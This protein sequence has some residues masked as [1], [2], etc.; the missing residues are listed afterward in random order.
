SKRTEAVSALNERF[1]EEGDELR[2]MLTRAI[3]SLAPP[4]SFNFAELWEDA[5]ENGKQAYR[6]F[7]AWFKKQDAPVK[8]AVSL[9][10]VGFFVIFLLVW[11]LRRRRQRQRAHAQMQEWLRPSEDFGSGEHRYGEGEE[12]EQEVMAGHNR[13]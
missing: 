13:F 7:V 10:P 1:A 5:Q 11:R 4:S 2:P 6:N 8:Y 3:E 12:E 9:A